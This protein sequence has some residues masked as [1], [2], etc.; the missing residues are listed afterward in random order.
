MSRL[1]DA[2]NW[3][4]VAVKRADVKSIKSMALAD[5]DLE[6]LWPRIATLASRPDPS[7]A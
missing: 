2:W 4:L 6:P 1:E 3:L 7:A 5:P